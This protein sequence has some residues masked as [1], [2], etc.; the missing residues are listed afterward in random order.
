M[1]KK[2]FYS[3]LVLLVTSFVANSQT[4]EDETMPWEQPTKGKDK[5]KKE[6]KAAKPPKVKNEEVA[7]EMEAEMPE[8]EDPEADK[9]AGYSPG[10]GFEV[11]LR[12]GLFQILGEIKRGSP[13]TVGAF[14]NYGF[15]GSLRFAL[16]NIFSLRAEFLYGKAAGNSDGLNPSLRGFTSTWMSGSLWGLINLN[17]LASADK[18]K[19][20]AIN[21]KYVL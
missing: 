15:A 8:T 4:T 20:M 13:D 18:E 19:K 1:L 10:S 7:P 17:S 12:G 14:S 6:K 16:D 3:L 9:P 11:G 21:L 2:I 5:P